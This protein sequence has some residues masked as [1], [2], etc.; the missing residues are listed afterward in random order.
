MR[1][2][3][4][5]ALEIYKFETNDAF[6]GFVTV[7]PFALVTTAPTIDAVPVVL[8]KD[9]KYWESKNNFGTPYG[10]CTLLIVD[11]KMKDY[12]SYGERRCDNDT[13]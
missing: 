4:A 8:C 2:I 6:R 1:M 13:P 7:I 11:M 5:D 9:C 12:C 3:D 10:T